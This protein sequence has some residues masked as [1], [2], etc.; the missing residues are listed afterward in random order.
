LIRCTER[1]KVSLLKI[2]LTN[3]C[4][5]NHRDTDR[6]MQIKRHLNNN[7]SKVFNNVKDTKERERKQ[8][9]LRKS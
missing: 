2:F 1:K 8:P 5:V 3:I 7:W 4:N 9:R 6:Q